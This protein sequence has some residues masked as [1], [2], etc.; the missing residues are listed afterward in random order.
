MSLFFCA[1]AFGHGVKVTGVYHASFIRHSVIDFL[2]LITK[3]SAFIRFFP[4]KVGGGC[5]A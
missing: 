3:C 1:F 4:E 2:L 5:G